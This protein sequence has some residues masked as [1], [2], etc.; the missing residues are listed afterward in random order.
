MVNVSKTKLS[1][2]ETGKLA[3]V[4]QAE[5]GKVV[6]GKQQNIE[7]L[8]AAVLANGNILFEDFPGLAKTLMSNTLA[9]TL[10][11]KF[12]RIQFTPDLL[13]A[14]LTGSYLFHQHSGEMVFRPG[15]V[16]TQVLLADEINRTPPK[17]QAALLEA[18]Q[19]H[20][21]SVAGKYYDLPEP[22]HVLATQNPLELEGT[23]PLPEAQLDRFF[24]QVDVD[25]PDLEG[26]RQIIVNTTGTIVPEPVQV[27]DAKAL[28]EA[29]GL[30]RHVPVGE[31]VAEAILEL[32]RAG[33]PETSDIEDVKKSVS[34]GPGPRAT[35]A[36]MLG[37]RARSVIEGRLAPSIDDVLA[38]VHPI[39]RH[40]MALTFS[41]RAEGVTLRSIIDRLCDRIA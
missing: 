12:K 2:E 15:P 18:M 24:M 22:F 37:V 30:V 27:M 41:A 26:E 25:Y 8:M 9:D 38:L 11:C 13:P 29:Q 7:M 32:V 31:S 3:D 39:L 1:I 33:R 40:R 14:D 28:V 36:L 5:V 4:I 23:Y 17:T 21:V 20:R 19:E 35:Q 10:G 34:W 6:L 16:H